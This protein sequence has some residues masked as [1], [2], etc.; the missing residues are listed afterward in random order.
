MAEAHSVTLAPHCPLG[1]IAFAAS[2]QIDFATPNALMGNEPRHPLQRRPRPAGLPRRHQRL[3]LHR[4]PH[5]PTDRP[6]GLGIEIDEAAVRKV[7]EKGQR[8]RVT[9]WGARPTAP[10]RSGRSDAA[11]W[12][13]GPVAL[14]DV[15]PVRTS[16][17]PPP[18]AVSHLHLPPVPWLLAQ[19]RQRR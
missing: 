18:D 13:P 8:W 1:P 6:P 12:L 16:P 17:R 2:L 9:R 3:R 19:H 5:R 14:R 10:W 11:G 15:P 4:Q 7:A